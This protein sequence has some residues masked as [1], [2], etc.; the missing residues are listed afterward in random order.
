MV[1]LAEMVNSLVHALDLK[2][3]LL[4]INATPVLMI[5]LHLEMLVVDKMEGLIRD[6]GT[7]TD[8]NI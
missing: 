6:R 4:S 1:K 2:S 5:D 3:I 8:K 7:F